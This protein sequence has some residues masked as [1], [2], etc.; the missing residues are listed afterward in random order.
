MA[1][2]KMK[3]GK[4]VCAKCGHENKVT[5]EPLVSK[6][7]RCNSPKSCNNRFFV[8]MDAAGFLSVG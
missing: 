3:E 5:I 1:N 6:P 2:Q 7:I 4:A 8:K